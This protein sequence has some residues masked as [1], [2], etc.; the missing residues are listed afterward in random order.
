MPKTVY[1]DNSVL[2]K[3]KKFTFL[4]G[5]VLAGATSVGVQSTLG[6]HSLTTSSGQVI[7][8]GELGQEKAEVIRTSATTAPGGTG[9]TLLSGEVLR[10][11]HPQDTKVYIIDWNRF[12][13]RWSAS[14]T[15]TLSTLMTYPEFLQPDQLESIYRDTT[16]SAGFYFARFNNQIDSTNSDNSDPIPFGGYNDNTVHALKQRALEQLNEK[17][18]PELITDEFLNRCLWQAR[19]EYHQMPGKRPFRRRFDRDIGNALTGS[20]YIELPDD[21]E[22]PHTAEN[23]FGVRIGTNDNMRYIDKK[24][25]DFYWRDNPHSTLELSYTFNTSTSIWLANGR[26]FGG[27]ATIKFENSSVDVTRVVG[28]QNSFYIYAHATG[29][30]NASAGSDAYENVS[31]GLPDKFTVFAPVGGGSP[32][33]YFNRPIDTAYI[34]QNIYADYYTKVVEFQT[35]ADELDEPV[36][37]FYVQYLKAKIKQKKN[38]DLNLANDPDYQLYL[39]GKQEAWSKEY[40]GQSVRFEPDIDHLL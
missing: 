23:V 35:D 1:V 6:F 24:E 33:I 7:L 25:W 8:I 30:R 9:V 28:E 12:E 20:F 37:D 15:G 14:A 18:D 29:N 26:D 31:F 19:R 34:N 39:L 10:F 2:V 11:D 16:Q 3:D 38:P 5:D 32:K 27:S 4:S 40:A 17:L 13:V 22:K 36:Y 21:V